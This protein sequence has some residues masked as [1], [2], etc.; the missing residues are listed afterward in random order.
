MNKNLRVLVSFVAMGAW[1]FL[2]A[3][4]V[5]HGTSVPVGGLGAASGLFL[6]G[7]WL[8]G[9]MTFNNKSLG[10]IYRLIKARQLPPMPPLATAIQT[11]ALLMA[12]ASIAYYFAQR[13]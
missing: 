4:N 2:C 13:N 3:L 7:G 11:V 1:V 12:V 9:R 6:I 5:A 8:G 10:E